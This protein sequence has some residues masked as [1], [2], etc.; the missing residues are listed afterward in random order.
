MAQKNKQKRH[1]STLNKTKCIS[2]DWPSLMQVKARYQLCACGF[3]WMMQPTAEF[4]SYQ[5]PECFP[6][7]NTLGFSYYWIFLALSS[8]E[9]LAPTWW[10]HRFNRI[11]K[12]TDFLTLAIMSWSLFMK[13]NNKTKFKSNVK[14]WKAKPLKGTILTIPSL[15]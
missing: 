6:K 11:W 10:M 13:K 9:T 2:T 8:H 1:S 5:R 7:D 12:Q 3:P 15:I 4:Q 14:K